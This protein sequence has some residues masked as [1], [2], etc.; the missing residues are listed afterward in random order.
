MIEIEHFHQQVYGYMKKYHKSCVNHPPKKHFLLNIHP[1]NIPMLM[2]SEYFWINHKVT[3]S[4]EM[5]WKNLKINESPEIHEN[6]ADIIP[7]K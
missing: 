1:D 3:D 5:W 4:V 7:I 2:K 6:F